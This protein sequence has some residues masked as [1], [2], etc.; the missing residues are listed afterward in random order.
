MLLC[1]IHDSMTWELFWELRMYL[2]FLIA[3]EPRKVILC[4]MRS[5]NA[6][7]EGF[8]NLYL[9]R[10]VNRIFFLNFNPGII[11]NAFWTTLN[12]KDI[13]NFF[14][15]L[16]ICSDIFFVR[17]FLEFFRFFFIFLELVGIVRDR[18]ESIG[19][20]WNCYESFEIDRIFIKLFG[21]FR[22]CSE[23]FKIAWNSLKRFEIV[24]NRPKCTQTHS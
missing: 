22:N 13:L 7:L 19:I 4:G 20:D 24:Q 16:L 1:D 14:L 18:S 12:S 11:L 10:G 23:L 5:F 3:K 2:T 15:N 17:N 6:W 8:W 9:S 21:N